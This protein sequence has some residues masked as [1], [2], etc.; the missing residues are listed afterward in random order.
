MGRLSALA[1]LVA[2]SVTIANSQTEKPLNHLDTEYDRNMFRFELI[3][4]RC[5]PDKPVEECESKLRSFRVGD[6]MAFQLLVTNMSIKPVTVPMRD[7]L[8]MNHPEL[9]R[10]GQLVPYQAA[11]AAKLDTGGIFPVARMDFAYL[12]PNK[13]RKLE[14]IWLK[15][16][17]DPLQIGH[18]QLT[19]Q[20]RFFGV[21]QWIDCEPITFEV[22]S[23]DHPRLNRKR[24]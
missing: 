10:D 18:Y 9:Y 8:L 14:T 21:D 23:K 3:P 22:Q 24:G 7:T 16:W 15:Y 19:V 4:G 13:R 11:L 12:E 17:Y 2:A 5:D 6:D 20:H 1:I